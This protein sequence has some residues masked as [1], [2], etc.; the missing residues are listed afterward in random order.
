MLVFYRCAG[1]DVNIYAYDEDGQPLKITVKFL[2]I[3][4]EHKMRIGFEA[5]SCVIIAR[6]EVDK[7]EGLIK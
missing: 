5:P 7:F 3:I 4:G 6:K 2:D 1:E